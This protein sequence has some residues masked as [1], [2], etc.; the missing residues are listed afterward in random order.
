MTASASAEPT[1]TIVR[2]DAPFTDQK[3]G[4]SGLRKS[5]QQFEQLNTSKAL[6]KRSSDPAR[7]AGGTLVLGG[8]G[9]YGNKRAID[10]ILRMGAAHGLGTLVTTGGILSTPAASIWS[11]RGRRSEASFF[12]ATIPVVPMATSA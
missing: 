3:P 6:S 9:R 12:P 1:H 8:D 10:V 4:T 2:L 5:S 7:R 11:A